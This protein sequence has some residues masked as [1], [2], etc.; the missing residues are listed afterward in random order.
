MFVVCPVQGV[1]NLDT[2]I[3]DTVRREQLSETVPLGQMMIQLMM[4]LNPNVHAYYIIRNKCISA[5][6]PSVFTHPK[7]DHIV[8]GGPDQ[9]NWIFDI[10]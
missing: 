7:L 10:F 4:A 9:P 5:F 3:A 1:A 8:L 2:T 6:I